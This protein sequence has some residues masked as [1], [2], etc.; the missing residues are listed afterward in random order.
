MVLQEGDVVLQVSDGVAG[1]L[2]EALWLPEVFASL[3][4]KQVQEIAGAIHARTLAERGRS[5]DI[6]VLVTKVEKAS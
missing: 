5:D 1:S 4:N 3:G 2:E 6:T